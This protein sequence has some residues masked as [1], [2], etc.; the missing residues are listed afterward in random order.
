[1][2]GE[3]EKCDLD[4]G[5]VDAE[6]NG[7]HR[8]IAIIK[9][10]YLMSNHLIAGESGEDE[11]S[12]SKSDSSSDSSES[13]SSS[14]TGVARVCQEGLVCTPIGNGKGECRPATTTGR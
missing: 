1:M 8:I 10:Q 3:G 14:S 11:S 9:I 6:D 12:D 5:S 2:V 13:S 7:M 4:D